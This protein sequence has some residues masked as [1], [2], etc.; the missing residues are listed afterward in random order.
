M[1]P[2]DQSTSSPEVALPGGIKKACYVFL[3][4]FLT[5]ILAVYLRSPATWEHIRDVLLLPGLIPTLL[6]S[7][8]APILTSKVI[9]STKDSFLAKGFGGRD[10]LK[11]TS[12]RI[13]ES[14]G[15]PTSL[16][17]C[18]LM[19]CF[20]PFR[21]GRLSKKGEDSQTNLDGG[22]SGDMTGRSGFPHH[23]VSWYSL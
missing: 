17:Y 10:L 20:I 11:G 14:L 19:F 7:F 16:L 18:M 21:Y 9:H 8:L 22:W 1:P 23:E 15:L 2:T 13:P 3:P 12:N 6:L 4:F 5:T